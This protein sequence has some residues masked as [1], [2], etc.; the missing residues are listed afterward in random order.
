MLSEP[1]TSSFTSSKKMIAGILSRMKL[2]SFAVLLLLPSVTLAWDVDGHQIV[3]II[4]EEHLAPATKD[5]IHALLGKDVGISDVGI[6]NWA[7]SVRRERK[8]TIP[9]H[10]IEIP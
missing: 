2:V 7:D 10:Y 6:C 3:A 5:G 4:A 1:F 8:E 9:W